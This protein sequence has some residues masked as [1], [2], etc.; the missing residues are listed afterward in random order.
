MKKS[1]T[2]IL[3]GLFMVGVSGP[4]WAGVTATDVVCTGCVNDTDIAASAVTN[5]KI[6]DGAVTDTKILDGSVATSKIADG[7]VTE[8]KIADGSVTN[9][10]I[11]GPISGAKLGAH[12]HNG[13]DIT[14]GTVT[15]SKISD[16]AV[17]DAKITGPISSAKLEKPANV[18]IVAKSG[19]DFTSVQSSI[20][21]INPTA[22]NPYL[23]KVMPGVYG[24][25]IN[26]KSFVNLQGYGPEITI[27]EG[28][29]TCNGIHD[30]VISGFT[31]RQPAGWTSGFYVIGGATPTIIGNV[32]TGYP[33]G[34]IQCDTG[35]SSP[36]IKGNTFTGNGIGIMGRCLSHI[37]GNSI[38]GNG[39]G[40]EVWVYGPTPAESNMIE[41]NTIMNNNI[42]IDV[43]RSTITRNHITNNGIDING[44]R[45]SFISYNIF[46]TLT[47]NDWWTGGFNLKSDGTSW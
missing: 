28:G 36:I 10:K 12:T 18:I 34:G 45:Q 29:I 26:M 24:E 17:T 44:G 8:G 41:G 42:G 35:V 19:G 23:I 21:S 13:Y 32:I 46:D 33:Y 6:V 15:A 37:E 16:G 43:D 4:T 25:P 7:A 2:S 30:A 11:T 39:T 1:L 22:E 14:D 47:Q 20:D 31:L 5:A 3:I 40:I 27:V 38:I 9:V